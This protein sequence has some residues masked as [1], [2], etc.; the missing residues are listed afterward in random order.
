[1]AQRAASPCSDFKE[2]VLKLC[3]FVTKWQI[4]FSVIDGDP[5]SGISAGS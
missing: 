2:Q 4:Y 3:D 5:G 1:M